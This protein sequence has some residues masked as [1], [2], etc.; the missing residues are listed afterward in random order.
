MGVTD[1]PDTV[2]YMYNP[3]N[4]VLKYSRHQIKVKV[5]YLKRGTF[6]VRNKCGAVRCGAV[7]CS[8][9]RCGAVRCGAV[10]CSVVR[11]GAV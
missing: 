8:V 7:W 9:V 2:T 4:L 10:W 3:I 11:C 6:V 5:R 1:V